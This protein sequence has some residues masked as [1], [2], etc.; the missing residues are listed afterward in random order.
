MEYL[1]EKVDCK[2][3]LHGIGKPLEFVPSS[4]Y[5]ELDGKEK[6]LK[7]SRENSGNDSKLYHPKESAFKTNKISLQNAAMQRKQQFDVNQ[8][9][10]IL[11]K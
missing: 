5:F 9:M 10:N 8:L 2:S 4:K 11:P 6:K 3:W 1:S 7:H